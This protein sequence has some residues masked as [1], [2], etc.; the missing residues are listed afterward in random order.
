MN[1][2]YTIS[3]LQED[4]DSGQRM[5]ADSCAIALAC[6]RQLG[7][8]VKKIAVKGNYITFVTGNKFGTEY[9]NY[10]LPWQAVDFIEKF[11]ERES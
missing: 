8:Q 3:V 11:D 6:H 7:S 10:K 9:R 2:E 1:K 4:I 5:D